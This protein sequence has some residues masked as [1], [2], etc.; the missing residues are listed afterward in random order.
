MNKYRSLGLY[1]VIKISLYI[2]FFFKLAGAD[3]RDSPDPGIPASNRPRENP[4]T[5]LGESLKIDNYLF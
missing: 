4:M 2:L 5:I 3:F 1:L